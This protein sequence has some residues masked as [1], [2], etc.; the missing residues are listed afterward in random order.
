MGESYG[1]AASRIFYV[2]LRKQVKCPP[3]IAVRGQWGWFVEAK[4]GSVYLESVNASNSW[5][6]KT[7]GVE[8]WAERFVEQPK[9]D[10]DE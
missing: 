3:M 6:A 1:T 9:E 8:E 2:C 7:A 5:D 10:G 4:D